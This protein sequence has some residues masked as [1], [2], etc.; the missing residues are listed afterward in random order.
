MLLKVEPRGN[1]TPILFRHRG[2]HRVKD[3][4]DL[5][6]HVGD[7][8][9]RVALFED[10][11]QLLGSLGAMPARRRPRAAAARTTPIASRNLR[12]E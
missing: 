6:P 9:D 4:V 1:L 3:H 10:G 2:F 7:F 5:T 8:V 12:R 11:L